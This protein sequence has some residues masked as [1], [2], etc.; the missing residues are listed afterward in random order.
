LNKR[1]GGEGERKGAIGE[2]IREK[3][4]TWKPIAVESF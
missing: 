4:L 2:I 3:Q 1:I